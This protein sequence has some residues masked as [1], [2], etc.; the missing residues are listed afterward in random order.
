MSGCPIPKFTFHAT[1]IALSLLALS[2]EEKIYQT[3]NGPGSLDDPSVLPAVVFTLPPANSIGP[4]PDLYIKDC[5]ANYCPSYLQ[6]QV[7]FNKYMDVSSVRRAIG[8]ETT[9]GNIAADSGLIS[10]L[11]GDLFLVSP[12]D[13][14]GNRI[15]G[16]FRIGETFTMTV[17]ST[18]RDIHGNSLTQPFR[19]TFV[20]EPYFRARSTTP[21]DGAGDVPTSAT[22]SVR[23]NGRIDGSILDAVRLYP[24][25]GGY[26]SI[27]PDSTMASY[28]WL[29][30]NGSLKNSTAYTITV[31]SGAADRDGNLLPET[32]VSTFVTRPFV[33]T[34]T[35]PRN[36]EMDVDQGTAIVVNF[37]T[38][39]D[40]S[41]VRASISIDPPVDGIFQL[42]SGLASFYFQPL[43]PLPK[44]TTF[45]VRIDTTLRSA[46]GAYLLEPYEFAFTTTDFRIVYVYP[47]DGWGDVHPLYP[48]SVSTNALPDYST[49]RGSIH[50]EP[51]LGFEVTSWP[52]DNSFFIYPDHYLAVSTRYTVT[53]DTSLRSTEGMRLASATTFSFTTAP[54][55]AISAEPVPGSEN[56]T[57]TEQ[58][59]VGFNAEIDA[60]TA[61]AAFSISPPTLGLI[62]TAGT[63]VSFSQV[64]L[65]ARTL[66]T[67]TI[68]TSLEAY[69]GGGLQKPYSFSFTTGSFGVIGTQPA[70]GDTGRPVNYI[71]FIYF[72]GNLDTSSIAGSYALRDS[73][74]ALVPSGF[75]YYRQNPWEFAI[76]PDANL[77]PGTLY[78]VT[79]SATIRSKGGSMLEAPYIFS[80]RTAR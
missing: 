32:F 18:A 57:L 50:I 74:G 72:S 34:S 44:G 71:I 40:T 24:D 54:L 15:T 31:D 25:A 33:V 13:S 60:G 75:L 76:D 58:V 11:G 49:I 51:P 70:N 29:S 67:V 48:L 61:E 26:W 30:S 66:Y 9:S 23:F 56:V 21:A 5:V 59:S 8:L 55:A 39:L 78:T 46:N 68:D 12:V 10:V 53:I 16:N 69:H 14:N 7:R 42:Y 77:E 64:E 80:F 79:I 73:T 43:E 27:N 20:P 63:T 2:C 62:Y 38:R 65:A 47:P 4:Y 28:G 35:T 52:G 17:D 22:V 45:T 41:T 6:L 3:I 19:M 36:G 37:N 1:L